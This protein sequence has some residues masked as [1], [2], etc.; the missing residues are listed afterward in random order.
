MKQKKRVLIIRCGLLGDTVDATSVI[1]PIVEFFG[2]NVEISW[3]SKPE[4]SQ[5]FELDERIKKVYI[6]RH[7]KLPFF[8]NVDKFLIILNSLFKPF[9]LIL[10][11]EIGNKFNDVVRFSRSHY[12]I[13][14]PY[15][16]I[17]DDIFEEHR[18]N[19]QLRIL[20]EF[21]SGYDK[22]Y[23]IPSIV[24]KKKKELEDIF[25]IKNKYIVLCPTNSH[26]ENENYRGYRSWP[27]KNW[28]DLIKK[29]LKQ[30]QLNIL[31]VGS[32]NEEKYF[33]N[34]YPLNS[35]VF[36]LSGKTTISEL[37]TIMQHS[38]CVVATDSGS[39]HVAGA[40]AKNIVSIHGPTNYFQSAPYKTPMNNIKIATLN[41]ECSPCY[42]T[43]AIKECPINK[44][45]YDLDADTIFDYIKS[46]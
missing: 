4:S 21:F 17:N 8:L 5:L 32:K 3:V 27:I 11:L 23:A 25:P 35:R 18:V 37:I 2:K 45:M 1:N 24:G 13:G 38:Q 44:C 43:Q 42:D 12:K 36:D 16:Y 10:N 6:L 29:I 34:F 26:F 30:T 15:K 40:S 9:D 20:N 19:H 22:K 31:L 7:T 33:K 41:L 28:V 46:F 14:M 39:V